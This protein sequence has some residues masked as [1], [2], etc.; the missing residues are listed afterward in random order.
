MTVTQQRQPDAAPRLILSA[1]GL[2]NSI[3]GEGPRL[4]RS[5]TFM[6][7]GG[8]NLSCIWCDTPYTW[9]WTGHSGKV[10]SPTEELVHKNFDWVLPILANLTAKTHSITITGGE[11]LLQFKALDALFKELR[12][13]T[14]LQ[15]IN[16]ETNGT[17]QI[18]EWDIRPANQINYV[19]SPKL[20]NAWTQPPDPHILAKTSRYDPLLGDV[21]FK[22]VCKTVAD[23]DE[24]ERLIEKILQQGGHMPPGRV[25]IMPE[26]TKPALLTL[27]AQDLVDAVVDRGWGL[28]TR[29]HQYIWGNTRAR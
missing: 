25:W 3:Q 13:G 12:W 7:L 20:K 22:F 6:R 24:V 21:D 14:P 16:F 19:V 18:P 10:Y 5:T 4:G 28:T 27:T 9:D 11:P 23:L 26:G 8:C 17:R 1:D 29:F 15:D 2:W